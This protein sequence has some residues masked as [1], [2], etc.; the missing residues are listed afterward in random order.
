MKGTILLAATI[1]LSCDAASAAPAEQQQK[2]VLLIYNSRVEMRGNVVV[3]QTLR[4]VL[5]ETFGFDVDI[6]SE[7]FE[8][9]PSPVEDF[10]F[11]SSWL[12]RKYEG[13]TFDVVVPV[14]ATSLQFVRDY[15]QDLFHGS[16]IVFW[17]RRAGL[18][19]WGSGM[20]LT[21]VVAPEMAGQVKGTF[22]FIRTLQPDL[23]QLIVIAGTAAT[24]REWIATAQQVLKPFEET[25]AI[26]YVAG[27]PVEDLETVVANL[28][29]RTAVLAFEITEDGTGRRLLREQILRRLV[30][31]SVAPVYSTSTLYLDT[32]I[33]GGTLLNQELMSHEAA[34]LVGRLLRGGN[35]E[36]MPVLESSLMPVVNWQALKRWRLDADKLPAGTTIMYKEE[37]A[38]DKYRWHIIGIVALILLQGGLI[39]ALLVQRT[40]RRQAER[41]MQQSNRLLLSTIDALNARVALLDENGTIIAV[42]RRWQSFVDER[43]HGAAAFPGD[44]YL[45][46]AS[47]SDDAQLISDGIKR[48][49]SGELEDFRCI[50]PVHQGNNVSWFQVRVNRFE[51]FGVLRFVV[52]YED[53]S[54]IKEAHD[55][56]Q[57]LTGLLLRAQDQERR[58]IARDLHDVTVQNVAAIRADLGSVKK[59]APNLESG[60]ED[61]LQEGVTL[62]DEVIKEL[63]TLSYLLHPPF[64]DDAGLVPALQWFVRGFIQRSEIN[65]DLLIE[66]DIGRLPAEIETALFR[67]VQESLTNIHRHSGCRNAVI[68]L[69]KHEDTVVLQIKDD[70]HGFSAPPSGEDGAPM[71]GV[72][73]QGMR[74]RLRQLGGELEVESSPDGTRVNARISVEEDRSVEN[75]SGR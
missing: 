42:N 44:S 29:P 15:G 46:A 62:C 58:R 49:K 63:R 72:G 23:Q 43:G 61:L 67:V 73:I 35:L 34:R 27:L 14:G 1:C 10:P 19:A 41:A 32:G 17:G 75:F 64:L 51:M 59:E 12:R 68:S 53:V 40:Q 22:E 70:G 69:A 50:Y 21:G 45:E 74:Q 11:F 54:E 2:S 5:G 24:N 16:Q 57:Q 71:L 48:V 31:K 6:S 66:N 26:R 56:Q 65:V 47:G 38:L 13:R 9:P 20:R 36:E 4:K 7:Y 25:I 60:A 18:D 39:A 33:V 55:A 30:Q 8:S 37:S 28:S 52:T 3:D